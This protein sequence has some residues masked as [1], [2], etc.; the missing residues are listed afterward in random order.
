MITFIN[1]K[2]FTVNTEAVSNEKGDFFKTDILTVPTV[3]KKNNSETAQRVFT[4][5]TSSTEDYNDSNMA[6]HASA[7]FKGSEKISIRASERNKYDSDLVMVAIPFNGIAQPIEPSHNFRI[8][9]GMVATS[10]KRNIEYDGNLYKKVLYLMIEPNNALFKP[11]HK[12]HVDEINLDF[13]SYNLE[14]KEDATTTTVKTT[15]TLRITEGAI[16]FYVSSEECEEISADTFRGQKLFTTMQHNTHKGSNHRNTRN[17]SFN[18][19]N[20]NREGNFNNKRHGNF[21]HKGN[22]N[23]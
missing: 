13:V 5:I 18:R 4:K 21:H 12:Y 2:L 6:V 23:A 1:D 20:G 10:N 16:E 9:K 8:H 7:G 11:D 17:N 22:R 19:N 14:T 15:S 3:L